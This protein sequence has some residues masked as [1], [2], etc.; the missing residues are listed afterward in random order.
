MISNDVKG[1][2]GVPVH[3]HGQCFTSEVFGSLKCDC[4]EQLNFAKT[5]T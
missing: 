5:Y 2:S 3:V 1:K 4:K